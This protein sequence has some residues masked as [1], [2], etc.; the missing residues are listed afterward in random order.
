M[1][2]SQARNAIKKCL[3]EIIYPR[4]TRQ[5]KDNIW[6]YFKNRCAYCEI[7][8]TK[9]SRK[10]HIDHLYSEMEGGSNR[11]SNLVLT[12]ATCNGDEK[13]ETNWNEFLAKKC[14]T[15]SKAYLERSRQIASWIEIN[16]GQPILTKNEMKILSSEFEVINQVLSASIVKLKNIKM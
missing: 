9:E 10:G 12:C 15:D 11:L 2:P 16:G 5:D 3:K 8:L 6:V 1:T 4:P 7:T 13:R 14:A